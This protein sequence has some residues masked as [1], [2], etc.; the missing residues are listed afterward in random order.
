MTDKLPRHGWRIGASQIAAGAFNNSA[1]RVIYLT[2]RM[3][4]LTQAGEHRRGADYF[5]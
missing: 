2:D 4:I 1:C 3:T 5:G